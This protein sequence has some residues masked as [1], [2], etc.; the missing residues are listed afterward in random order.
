MCGICGFS[1]RDGSLTEA[2]LDSMN[3]TLIRRGPDDGGHFWKGGTGIA[4]RRLSIQDIEG[5]HQ[6]IFNEDRN[7]VVVFNGEIYNFHELRSDLERKGHVFST[8]TDTEVIVHLYEEYGTET[9]N[10]LRGMFAFA[11]YDTRSKALFIARDRLGIKP[12]FYHINDDGILFASEI[13][14]LLASGKI[15]KKIDYQAL[16]AF[17][18]FTYIPAP[19]SIYTGIRKLEPGTSLFFKDGKVTHSRYWDLSTKASTELTFEDAQQQLGDTLKDAV[20]SHLV[21]DVPVGAFLSGGVDSSMVVA[22]MRREQKESMD[23][24]TVGFKGKNIHIDDERPYARLVAERYGAHLNECEVDPDFSEIAHDIVEAFDEP[25][26]DDSV[27]PTYYVCEKTS[28]KVKVALTGLGGDELFAGYNRYKGILISERFEWIPKPLI[29]YFLQPLANR[30]PN[31]K[32]GSEPVDYIKRFLNGLVLDPGN[33]Y[34]SYLSSISRQDKK[35]LYT[36]QSMGKINFDKT[37][38]LIL[39]HYQACPSDSAISKALYT[40]IKTYLPEDILALS[41]RVSM[42]HSLELRVPLIDHVLTEFAFTL[43]DKMKID[44]KQTKLILKKY[45]GQF[46]PKK[47][48]EHKKQGFE[49]PMAGWLKNELNELMHELLDRKIIEK[50][51]IF[52]YSFIEKLMQD[53]EAGIQK[54]NKILFSLMMFQLWFSNLYEKGV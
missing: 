3:Q 39:E 15:K 50:Q 28:Q 16:D 43:P 46:L 5:G 22:L 31:P 33:R 14:A 41:D 48:L 47:V 37:D 40:D 36:S 54:N 34:L 12:L 19:L 11:L 44:L 30:I 24:F 27:V 45:A 9:P 20:E 53:H 25:F 8:H 51:G 1:V 6:P 35:N 42:W 2:V 29:K 26:A 10:Y 17:L 32:N 49:S 7:L 18:T 4:M 13:K 38:N 52:N 21:S 23:V